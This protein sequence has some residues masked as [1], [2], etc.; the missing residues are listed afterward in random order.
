[1]LAVISTIDEISI[2]LRTVGR[3]IA[4]DF[5]SKTQILNRL[6]GAPQ[7]ADEFALFAE[8]ALDILSKMK[9]AL[10]CPDTEVKSL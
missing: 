7:K 9:L 10:I 1:M 6:I 5:L 4:Y 3:M 2:F 8:K